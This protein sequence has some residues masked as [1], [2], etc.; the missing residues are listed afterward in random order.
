MENRKERKKKKIYLFLS[1][2]D[3]HNSAFFLRKHGLAL[4]ASTCDKELFSWMRDCD[5]VGSFRSH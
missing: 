2:I 5:C 4:I 3:T 1:V